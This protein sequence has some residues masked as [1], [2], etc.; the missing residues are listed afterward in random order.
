[1]QATSLKLTYGGR[2]MGDNGKN[3]DGNGMQ[4]KNGGRDSQGVIRRALTTKKREKFLDSYRN[5]GLIRV[6]AESAGIHRQSHYDWLKQDPQYREQ[7][8][9][10]KTEAIEAL[11]FEAVTR[12][13]VGSLKPI[14]YK[15]EA[16]TVPCRED[17][18]DSFDDPMHAG[19]FRKLYMQATK[20]DILL[21]FLLKKLDPSYREG[22][23]PP[24]HNREE[25]MV[26]L[27]H[28]EAVI[29]RALI[30][31]DTFD[32]SESAKQELRD[33]VNAPE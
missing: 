14:F 26:G 23:V 27:S 2:V 25:S 31:I 16:I 21:M 30:S 29:K 33:R 15:G 11:E 20:S 32:I 5:C 8:A 3:G 7:F 19:H 24:R 1:M 6:A 13:T 17:D 28:D 9:E 18:P 22:Y 12:A 4:G 10:A